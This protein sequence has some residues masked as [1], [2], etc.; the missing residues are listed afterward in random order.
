MPITLQTRFNS[1]T[2]FTHHNAKGVAWLWGCKMLSQRCRPSCGRQLWDSIAQPC[3]AGSVQHSS[4][5]VARHN[6][7]EVNW[8]RYLITLS[9]GIVCVRDEDG[10]LISDTCCSCHQDGVTGVTDS[11]LA[12][13]TMRCSATVVLPSL[14]NAESMTPLFSLYTC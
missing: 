7:A 5:T 6:W 12:S 3:S 14:N 8:Y 1:V 4:V 10:T 9:E 11:L 13:S 2:G